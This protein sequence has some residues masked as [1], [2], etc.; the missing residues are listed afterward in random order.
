M[1]CNIIDYKWVRYLFGDNE[2]CFKDYTIHHYDCKIRQFTTPLLVLPT[3]FPYH[4][5]RVEWNGVVQLKVF[6]GLMKI[7]GL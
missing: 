5:N 4:G 7:Y 2:P 1:N 6:L 3:P